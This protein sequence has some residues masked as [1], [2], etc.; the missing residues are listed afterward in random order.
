MTIHYNSVVY[1][2][3]KNHL[4]LDGATHTHT[5][6]D[7]M[8]ILN[9]YETSEFIKGVTRVSGQPNI[10]PIYLIPTAAFSCFSYHDEI[11]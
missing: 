11:Q 1:F 9:D 5:H 4:L 2:T 3:N 8:W 7:V 10:V 6:T